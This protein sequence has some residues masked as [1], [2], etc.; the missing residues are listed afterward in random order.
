MTYKLLA[1][2]VVFIH[3]LWLLFLVFGGL[4]GVRNRTIRIF[5]IVGLV[6]AFVIQVS[7]WYCPFTDLEVWLRSRHA[8]GLAYRGSFIIHYIEELVYV[9]VPRRLIIVLTGVVCAFYGWLY[10]RRKSG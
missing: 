4:C 5:H 8:P 2:L 7:G 10:L 9:E 3:F 1:D 6:F